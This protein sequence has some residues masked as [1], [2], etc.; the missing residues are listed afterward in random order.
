MSDFNPTKEQSMAETAHNSDV[1]VSASAGSGKT[2]ILIERILKEILSG[3][4]IDHLLIVTFTE[5]ASREMKLRLTK[6]LRTAAKTEINPKIRQHLYKQ[7]AKV[8][9]AYI[10]TLHAF[11]LRVIRKFYYL[12][13]IDPAFRL[14]S[15]DNERYLLQERAWEKVKQ[16]YYQADDQEFFK[17]ERNF[18]TGG[19]DDAVEELFFQLSSFALTSAEP[20]HWLNHLTDQ[21]QF[22]DELTQTKFYQ[23]SFLPYLKQILKDLNLQIENGLSVI[24]SYEELDSYHKGFDELAEQVRELT[25]NF[26]TRTWDELQTQIKLLKKPTGRAKAKTDQNIKDQLSEYRDVINQEIDD[27]QRRYFALNNSQWHQ[28]FNGSCSIIEK[29]SE[30]ENKFLHQFRIEKDQRHSLDFNDLEHFTMSILQAKKDDH[31]IAR[32]YY[33]NQFDEILIDEYQD[34]N[35]LQEAIVQEFKQNDPGNLFMVGDVKQSIYGFRQAAP[36]LFTNK[37]EKMQKDK[38]IG[39]LVE[40]SDNFRS[41]ANVDDTVNS[42]FEKTMD[43]QIG[44]M[45]YKGGAEL[46][47]GTNFPDSADTV[48]EYLM[49]LDKKENKSKLNS[50]QEEINLIIHKI[51][52]MVNNDFQIY[53]A[54]KNE[55]RTIRYSDIAIL[56]RVKSFN[57]DIVNQF[58]AA[59]V[60]VV[61]NDAANY[62]QATEVQIML[63]MLQIIDNPIQDIPLVAVLRSAIVGLDENELAYIRINQKTGNYYQAILKYLYDTKYNQNGKVAK[64][65]T[66]KLNEFMTQLNYFRDI[67]SKVPISEL[68]WQI[69]LRTGYLSYVKGM[70]NGQ[71]RTINLHALYQ[72]A[73]Q[74]EAMGFRG[75]FQF[76]KFIEHIQSNNK[77]LARPTEFDHQSNEVKVMTI[78]GSKGLEFPIVFLLSTEHRFNNDDYTK[79]KYIL[80]TV[81]GF[82]LNYLDNETH[83]SYETL[84]MAVMR[85]RKKIKAM[86]EELRLLYVALTRAKQK[87]ILVGATSKDPEKTLEEWM[88]PN[89]SHGT[90][91]DAIIREKFNSFYDVMKFVFGASSSELVDDQIESVPNSKFLFRI[92]FFDSLPE[93]KVNQ[94]QEKVDK[95]NNVHVSELFKETA[96]NIL[97]FHYPEQEAI[98]TTAYQSVSEI[99]HLFSNPDDQNLPIYDTDKADQNKSKGNRFLISD[100]KRPNFL[101][102]QEVSVSAADVGSATHLLL[103]KINLNSRPTLADFKNLAEH[104]VKDKILSKAVI[105]KIDYKSLAQFYESDL[106]T[107]ILKNQKNLKREWS[108]S[109]LLPAKVVYNKDYSK[110][111]DRILV[112]GIVDGMFTDNRNQITIFDYK[113]D[114]IEPNKTSG[115][116]SVKH[117]LQEYS[118]QLNLYQNAVEKISQHKVIN[119][120]LCLLSINQVVRVD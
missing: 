101:S 15:D 92:N 5:A 39:Q 6:R 71:Q 108:F 104:L 86:S 76:I 36:Y 1:L 103:Q 89:D 119:K 100:F 62:F 45:D 25:T 48:T 19:S 32:D 22:N 115:D 98:Q 52:S 75:L 111:D 106:G 88:L 18:S 13:N 20:T 82:G 11:C 83:I 117:A 94:Q 107:Q 96:K 12:I 118:G 33:R 38:S 53:D 64:E 41:A 109:M 85:Q 27:L 91:I 37:F 73:D 110:Y 30:V 105:D 70:P 99:K 54:K 10:S 2:T 24:N 116:H 84:Q 93:I 67:S 78:H 80:D 9:S 28:I 21:Y 49:H 7:I 65:I 60:P 72:R 113:T 77:D 61:V 63:S 66:K 46:V 59:N 114:F 112:H 58:A 97:D 23:D 44:D 42:I 90:V 51:Q 120:Y 40:L 55:M 14:V 16:T 8:P 3:Q 35:P 4:E 17:M 47:C 74:F 29:V 34:T 57:N 26:R 79:K 43:K 95:I 68:I 87:L 102:N 81:N 69:Y 31:Q 50:K 56:T